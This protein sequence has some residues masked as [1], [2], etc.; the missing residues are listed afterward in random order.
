VIVRWLAECLHNGG[1]NQFTVSHG[2][3]RDE[4]HTILEVILRLVRDLEGQPRFAH[5]ACTSEGEQTHLRP[6]PP[7]APVR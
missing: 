4:A 2:G 3:E 6:Q 1:K 5:A 7:L